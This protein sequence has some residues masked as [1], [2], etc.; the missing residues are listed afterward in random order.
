[1]GS[2]L[3]TFPPRF[4]CPAVRPAAVREGPGG[5]NPRRGSGRLVRDRGERKEHYHPR[6]LW[7]VGELRGPGGARSFSPN[8]VREPSHTDRGPARQAAGV[9][10]RG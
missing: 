9:F 2:S 4:R 1:M 6:D 3:G 7:S 8:Q 10:G 5:D